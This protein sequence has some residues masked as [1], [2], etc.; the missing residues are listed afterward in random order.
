MKVKICGIT[1]LQDAQSAVAAGA[2]AVGFIFYKGSPRAVS[3]EEVRRIVAQLPPFV[4]GVGVF[5][6]EDPRVVRDVMA[7]CGLAVAQLH[8]NEPAAYCSSL[9]RPVVKAIRLKDRSSLLALAQYAGPAGVRAILLDSWTEHG[10]GGSG[11]QADWSLAAEV[12]KTHPVVLAGGLTPQNV[13]DAIRR[14][15]PYGVD[16]S[17]GVE[18]LP[19]KKD[20]EKIQAFVQ[21]VKLVSAELARYT[22]GP[23]G[24]PVIS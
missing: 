11:Q 16:V 22:P 13:A 5:V 23:P 4:V 21:S 18:A 1:N 3:V 8:G 10:Y 20:S 24:A 17:S 19:G 2:D 14:V 15:H 6:N 12:A 9:D 7:R